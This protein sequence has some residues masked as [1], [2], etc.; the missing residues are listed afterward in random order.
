M[1]ERISFPEKETIP[2]VRGLLLTPEQVKYDMA[3]HSKMG[4][5]KKVIYNGMGPDISSVLF[6]TNT[7]EVIGVDRAAFNDEYISEYVDRY[8][9]LLDTKPVPLAG[10]IFYYRDGNPENHE[11]AP[12][13]FQLFYSHRSE[14][15]LRGYWDSGAV[16]HWKINRLLFM[17]LKKMGVEKSSIKIKSR[18]FAK[19]I[20]FEWAYPGEKPK[21]RKLTYFF[22]DLERM[23][24]ARQT[25]LLEG[26]DTFYQKSLPVNIN[27]LL[28]Y[29]KVGS[30]FLIPG[31]I[32]AL[33]YRFRIF[34]RNSVYRRQI[35]QVLGN[36]YS[37]IM[38][39]RDADKLIDM[40][41]DENDGHE[42]VKYGMKLNVYLK[43]DCAKIKRK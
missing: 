33:G 37:S 23:A 41:P 4:D 35:K 29:I 9:D 31:G 39:G 21:T 42:A 36:E 22:G 14:R 19:E 17:E 16:G 3:W 24:E 12:G 28:N 26:A 10:A 30:G 32:M 18:K 34:G 25:K 6:L 11:P 20:K 40:L 1:I 38:V 13:E 8:W 27:K 2:A 5:R 15:L 43:K 7:R